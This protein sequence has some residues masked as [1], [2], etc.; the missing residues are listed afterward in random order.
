MIIRCVYHNGHTEY[1][2]V[3]EG[4]HRAFETLCVGDMVKHANRCGV[5]TRTSIVVSQRQYDEINGRYDA[6]EGFFYEVKP[7]KYMHEERTI[8]M[9]KNSYVKKIIDSKEQFKAIM[10]I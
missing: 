4:E 5:G 7:L 1:F 8:R 6:R 10:E 3:K 2:E 9:Y